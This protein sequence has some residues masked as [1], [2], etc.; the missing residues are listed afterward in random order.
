MLAVLYAAGL[1][2]SEAV[3]LDLSDYNPEDGALTVRGGKGRKDRIVY[4]SNGSKD[5]LEDWIAIRGNEAG[6]LFHPVNKGDRI[7][8]RRMSDQA[9][10]GIVRKRGKGGQHRSL[11]PSRSK[12]NL[13][14][15][16]AR[17]WC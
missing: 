9:V 15:R 10:L 17:C 11:Q 14:L 7:I 12:A 13:R 4:A 6:A 5:A 2:R 1:R 3:G 16:P 8:F